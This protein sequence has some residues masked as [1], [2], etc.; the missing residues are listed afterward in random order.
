M[1]SVAAGI[2]STCLSRTQTMHFAALQ[3]GFITCTFL[4]SES[5]KLVGKSCR[6]ALRRVWAGA[7]SKCNSRCYRP[8]VSPP[9][10]DSHNKTNSSEPPGLILHLS[11]ESEQEDL[12]HLHFVSFP[13][14]V[15]VIVPIY[16]DAPRRISED[17]GH[18]AVLLGGLGD[19]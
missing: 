1:A 11:Y 15:C 10:D 7:G 19:L 14:C 9:Q 4:T 13:M 6:W 8:Q 5:V 16:A 2:E 17:L 18:Y 3:D 12:K